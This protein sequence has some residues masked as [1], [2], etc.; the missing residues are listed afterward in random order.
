MSMERP[1]RILH[2]SGRR[3]WCGESN[4]VLVECRGLRE[5]GHDV[6]L[7]APDDTAI[8]Q[9]ARECGVPVESGFRFSKGFRPFDTWHDVQALKRLIASKPWD[10]VHPHTPRDTWPVALALGPRGRPGRPLFVRT[11]HHSLPTKNNLVHRWLYGRRIDH[12]ILASGALRG[13]ISELLDAGVLDDARL[14]VIHSSV[15]VARFDRAKTDAACIRAEF[16][17]GD[18]FVLG[19]V[20]RVSEEKGHAVLLDV[21]PDL[22]AARPDLACVFVGAGDQLDAVK[23]R[24]A[25]GPLRDVVVFA[26]ERRDVPD[27]V[28]AFDAQVVP[29]L[30]LEASPATIKEAMAMG[31]PVVASRVGGTDEIVADGVDGLLVPPGDRPALRDALLKLIRDEPFRRRLAAAGRPK[32]VAEFS[33]EQLVAR[34]IAAYRA[35]LAGPAGAH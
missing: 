13:T 30:W 20:G 31:V 25:A 5:R 4:R 23:A 32:V 14:A 11:K 24:V 12:F 26:G 28:A 33:D 18:R 34:A 22:V 16:K 27:F 15:D 3:A 8:A 17:L 35:M 1:L 21:L 9:R 29:S 6:L 7:A 19:L 2:L 10:I